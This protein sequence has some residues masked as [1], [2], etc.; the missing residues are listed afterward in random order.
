MLYREVQFLNVILRNWRFHG[1]L[2]YPLFIKDIRELTELSSKIAAYSWL[3]IQ[4]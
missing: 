4:V 3:Q 1:Q 2:K